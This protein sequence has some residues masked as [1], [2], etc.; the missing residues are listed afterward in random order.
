MTKYG[1]WDGWVLG[2]GIALPATHPATHRPH[3]PGYTPP[4]T[5]RT[6]GPTSVLYPEY[7][8][9][10]GLI[11]VGQLSLGVQI[12][13]SRGITEVYNLSKIGNINNHFFIPGND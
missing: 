10:V 7:N 9:V 5:G 2:T 8:S 13:G 1:Y 12:S 11:S 6:P 3:H 4:D